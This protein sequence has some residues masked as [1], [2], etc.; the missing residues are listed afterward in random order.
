M[1]INNDKH[2]ATGDVEAVV[3]SFNQ[4]SMILEAVHSLC[5]QT[6]P[7]ARI[8]IVDDGSTDENSIN[9]LNDIKTDSD[10]SI[11]VMVIQQPNGGVSSARN[12]GIHMAQAPMVLVLD[13]D[14]KLEPSYIEQVSRM[15]CNH[16]SMVAASSWLRTFG[17]LDATVCPCGGNIT[18]FLARNCCPAAHILRREVWKQCGGYD[19]SMRSGFEDWEFFLSMLETMPDACIGI[20]EE[21]LIDYR[22]APASSNVKSMMKRLELMRFMIEKHINTYREHITDAILGIESISIS[23]LYGWENEILHAMAAKQNLSELSNDFIEHPSYGDGG[24][25]AAVRILSAKNK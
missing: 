13:G 8:I 17:A 6:I 5:C 10:I 14:D 18:A 2:S 22:T 9:I 3:T 21:P 4:G 24:M 23:R 16:P 12:T 7:P 19:E 11:P 1:N 25:A 15:L 20:V